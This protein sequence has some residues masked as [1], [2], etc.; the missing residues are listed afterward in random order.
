MAAT[1]ADREA[2]FEL[3][4]LVLR[5]DGQVMESE[6]AWLERLGDGFGIEPARRGE[7]M[8][9]LEAQLAAENAD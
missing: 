3:A 9:E 6:L 7:L 4:A 5:A 1:P 8:A 2:L